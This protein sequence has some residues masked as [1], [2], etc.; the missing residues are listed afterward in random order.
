MSSN[1]GKTIAKLRRLAESG[2]TPEAKTA[3]GL[4][5][6]M[7][8]KYPGCEMDREGETVTR[9]LKVSTRLDGFDRALLVICCRYLGC[10]LYATK[11]K[12]G[13][14]KL[15][16][17]K[18]PAVACESVKRLFEN[19]QP[20]YRKH[21]EG[22]AGSWLHGALPTEETDEERQQRQQRQQRQGKSPPVLTEEEKEAYRAAH[23]AGQRKQPNRL[24][25]EG[26]KR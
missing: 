3:A 22:M 23:R 4:L 12:N 25:S 1:P 18:G 10:E 14:V 7:I 13:G 5:R 24:L 21:L 8:A 9:P 20:G 19:M 26:G 17:A 11:G 2:D 16:T 15:W 6:E